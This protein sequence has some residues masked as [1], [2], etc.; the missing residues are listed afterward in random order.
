MSHQW[1]SWIFTASRFSLLNFQP[2]KG[3]N[4]FS[5]LWTCL[6]F[7]TSFP[8]LVSHSL[9]QLFILSSMFA[10]FTMF[11]SCSLQKVNP[12]RFV[13]HDR[14]LSSCDTH[15]CQRLKQQ[16]HRHTF[17]IVC[18][19]KPS[20]HHKI[21]TWNCLV[22]LCEQDTYILY[23]SSRLGKPFFF[24]HPDHYTRARRKTSS[25]NLVK[26]NTDAGREEKIPSRIFISGRLW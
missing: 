25:T 26:T 6:K 19:I 15:H 10:I 23:P 21:K 24:S 12:L 5:F 18:L 20:A 1:T 4:D 9:V 13:I 16:H 7:S 2:F 14:W 3:T 22:P 8:S 17:W 11:F